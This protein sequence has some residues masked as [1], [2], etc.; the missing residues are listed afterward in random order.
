MISKL[1][2]NIKYSKYY[3]RFSHSTIILAW[4]CVFEAILYILII[5]SYSLISIEMEIYVDLEVLGHYFDFNIYQWFCSAFSNAIFRDHI[6]Y[7]HLIVIRKTSSVYK[8]KMTAHL[9]HYFR[10]AW[11]HKYYLLPHLYELLQKRIRYILKDSQGN[12]L[13]WLYSNFQL[14]EIFIIHTYCDVT[15]CF[16]DVI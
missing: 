10:S 6:S 9:T 7:S 11:K 2:C 4:M 13:Y 8:F 5:S 1:K 3:N 12:Y 16:S 15:S 14:L